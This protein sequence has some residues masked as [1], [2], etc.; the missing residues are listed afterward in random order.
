MFRLLIVLLLVAITL[1]S[2]AADKV[3]CDWTGIEIDSQGCVDLFWYDLATKENCS[4]MPICFK[5]QI[6]E[7]EKKVEPQ[8]KKEYFSKEVAEEKKKIIPILDSSALAFL[9]N[10]KL[11]DIKI[12]FYNKDGKLS[13]QFLKEAEQYLLDKG[14]KKD[15]FIIEIR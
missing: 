8:K 11:K 13:K 12:I 1:K 2:D 6:A 4:N 15:Q 7:E 5:I 3:P 9:K 10:G 14:V